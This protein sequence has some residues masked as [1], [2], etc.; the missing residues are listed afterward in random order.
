MEPKMVAVPVPSTYPVLVLIRWTRV[1]PIL[2][3]K[4]VHDITQ[5]QVINPC[6]TPSFVAKLF[7]FLL[8]GTKYYFTSFL[9]Y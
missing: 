6:K 2:H 5:I 8:N 4:W 3:D 1:L 7:V 9:I